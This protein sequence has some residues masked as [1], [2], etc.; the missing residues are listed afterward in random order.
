M[1]QLARKPFLS[2]LGASA[3]LSPH[4]SANPVH[5]PKARVKSVIYLFMNGGMSQLDSFNIYGINKENLGNSKPISSSA[6]G[7]QVSHYFPNMAKRMHQVCS[8]NTMTTNQGAHPQAQYKM[9]TSYNMRSSIKHPELGSWACRELSQPTDSLPNF[10]QINTNKEATAGFFPGKYSALSVEDANHGIRFSSRNK[11]IDA[12]RF[13]KRLNLLEKINRGF[14]EQYGTKDTESYQDIYANAVKFMKSKDLEAFD[15]QKETDSIKRLYNMKDKFN[16]GCLL[17]GRLVEKGVR[18]VQVQLGGWDHHDKIY[19]EFPVKAKSVDTGMSALMEHLQ[20]KGLWDST[21]IVL[22]SE[23]GRG[24]KVNV[25]AGRDHFPNAFTC[26]LAGGAVKGG[27]VYGKTSP[28]GKDPIENPVQIS[29]FNATIADAL[30]MDI[31]KKVIAPNGRPFQVAGKE[32]KLIKE[33]F[34]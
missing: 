24:I 11:S 30:G 6:D 22:A 20:Q 10:I 9:L 16:T 27:F 5:V 18:F 28:D 26:L 32:S 1:N 8:V 19:S 13:D 34:A 3:A 15:I 25:N 2:L 14:G 17:A 29:D 12:Q 23:F 21:M 4:L 33:V 7:V 31:T